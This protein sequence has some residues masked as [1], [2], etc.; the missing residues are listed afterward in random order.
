ML[1]LSLFIDYI[2]L[3]FLTATAPCPISSFLNSGS[4]VRVGFPFCY[5]LSSL[6]ANRHAFSP[7]G[8]STFWVSSWSP[9]YRPLPSRPAPWVQVTLKHYQSVPCCCFP[10]LSLIDIRHFFKIFPSLPPSV[11]NGRCLVIIKSV[12]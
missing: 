10:V 8:N 5:Y 3:C 4:G 7:L 11:V 2:V 12:L 1:F 6:P 9:F